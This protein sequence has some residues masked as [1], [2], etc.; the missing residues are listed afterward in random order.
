MEPIKTRCI[1]ITIEGVSYL[2]TI[3]EA[4]AL[5]NEISGKIYALKVKCPTC[6]CKILPGEVCFCCEEDGILDWLEKRT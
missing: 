5:I 4:K 2:F 3:E 1:D 6:R